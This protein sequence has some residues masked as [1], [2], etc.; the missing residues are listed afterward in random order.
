MNH[1]R[2]RKVRMGR[3][4]SDKMNKTVVVAVE[5]MKPHPL[6][7]K[8][9]RHTKRHKVHDANDACK[10]GDTVKIVETRPLSKEK[11]WR[12]T[13]IV[14]RKAGVSKDDSILHQA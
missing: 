5:V 10:V 14:P 6:Y 2:K 11:R 13:E 4:V 12:V 7:K 9:V 1:T 8:F 3:V